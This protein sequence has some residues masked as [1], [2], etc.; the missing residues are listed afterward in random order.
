MEL[1]RGS[2]GM[3]GNRTESQDA[4]ANAE[5][6]GAEVPD[7]ELAQVRK[8]DRRPSSP[9]LGSGVCRKSVQRNF[10][11][12]DSGLKADDA[13]EFAKNGWRS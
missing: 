12:I 6:S 11:I 4:E 9:S 3:S 7:P 1:D 10:S 2:S 13:T 5:V 8:D